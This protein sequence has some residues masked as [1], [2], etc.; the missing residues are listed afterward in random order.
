MPKLEALRRGWSGL[1]TQSARVAYSLALEAV[2]A[3]YENF[4]TDGVRNLMRSPERL[5]AISAELDK[6]LG[7]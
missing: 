4:G 2:D 7:L 1:D 5:P 3:L 6:R